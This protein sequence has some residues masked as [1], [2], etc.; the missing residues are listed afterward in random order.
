MTFSTPE[1]ASS[2]LAAESPQ[3][4]DGTPLT[5]S[6][7]REA[8]EVRKTA[9]KRRLDEDVE[10][11]IKRRREEQETEKR[12]LLEAKAKS[13]K[14]HKCRGQGEERFINR[15]ENVA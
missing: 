5:V 14:I 6:A 3:L 7:E 1:A 2:A 13:I 11:E 15:D 12:M 8:A 10:K 4:E 9:E